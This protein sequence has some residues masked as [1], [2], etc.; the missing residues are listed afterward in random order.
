MTHVFGQRMVPSY[1][2][3]PSQQSAVILNENCN[4]KLGAEEKA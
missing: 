3:L 1:S 4:S 2:S